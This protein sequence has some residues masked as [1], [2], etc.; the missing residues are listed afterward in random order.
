[1][2]CEHRRPCSCSICGDQVSLPAPNRSSEPA[3]DLDESAPRPMPLGG[4]IRWPDP[5]PPS[6]AERAGEAIADVLMGMVRT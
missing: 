1:M 3:A 6:L 4:P 5:A 2:T